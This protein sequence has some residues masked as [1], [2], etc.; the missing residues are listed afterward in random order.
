[1]NKEYNT[2]NYLDC[3]IT[4]GMMMTYLSTRISK[5]S[6]PHYKRMTGAMI[7]LL[8][9][10]PMDMDLRDLLSSNTWVYPKKSGRFSVQEQDAVS[11]L[12][13][14]TRP[15]FTDS[16]GN[17]LLASITQILLQ[18]AKATMLNRDEQVK[19]EYV[20]IGRPTILFTSE[21]DGKSETYKLMSELGFVTENN[22]DSPYWD[23]LSAKIMW[24][25]EARFIT[26]YTL[27]SFN[28]SISPISH[29]MVSRSF[30]CFDQGEPTLTMCPSISAIMLPIYPSSYYPRYVW[31][32]HI[33]LAGK[34][35]ELDD[36]RKY[37]A[38][39]TGRV[40]ES[41]RAILNELIGMLR[42]RDKVLAKRW[43]LLLEPTIAGRLSSNDI[44][45]DNDYYDRRGY[46]GSS[47]SYRRKR[48]FGGHG[49]KR[50][51]GNGNIFG[52]FSNWEAIP[53]KDQV[54]DL[55]SSKKS[56]SVKGLKDALP[57]KAIT[58]I[59]KKGGMRWGS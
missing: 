11:I 7:G 59:L 17:F 35:D 58:N 4:P 39:S 30:A 42:V 50:Y 49:F 5:L 46:G 34:I 29:E 52:V 44:V 13:G 53:K 9:C 25:H 6:T 18:Y 51:N 43:E 22:V 12:K 32:H 16:T 47:D 37:W 38:R 1:M 54:I 23:N 26:G 31:L 3:A 55:P 36:H 28:A 56:C 45:L 19:Y 57:Y 21:M 40:F 10:L 20:K 14:E 48:S 41:A 2:Y 8:V 24:P 27:Y 15:H 33:L